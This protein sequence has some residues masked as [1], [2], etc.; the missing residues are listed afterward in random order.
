PGSLGSLLMADRPFFLRGC[1]HFCTK[2]RASIGIDEVPRDEHTHLLQ[3][4]G[5][6][7]LPYHNMQMST[8]FRSRAN[9]T[10]L[11]LAATE[12][13]LR[14]GYR[15]YEGEASFWNNGY[16]FLFELGRNIAAG[17]G[18]GFG[19]APTAFR[20][21]AYPAFLAAVTLGRATFLPIVL[22]QAAVGAGTVLC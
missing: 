12:F 19:E 22:S 17:R 5:L 1:L 2:L 3:E 7:H 6:G 16:T 4:L 8:G 9:W 10:I 11:A 14:V 15:L 21:P 13:A 20:V 18:L